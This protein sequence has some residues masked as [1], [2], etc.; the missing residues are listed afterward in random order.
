MSNENSTTPMPAPPQPDSL[1][2]WNVIVHN[3]DVN[4]YM[5][6]IL[7]LVNLVKLDVPTAM[8]KTVEV[9]TEGLSIVATTHK[10]HAELMQEQLQ[11]ASLTCTIEPA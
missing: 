6:V 4:T 10:E 5:H 8:L 1:E 11:S 7:S 2:Q 3:D 9:D